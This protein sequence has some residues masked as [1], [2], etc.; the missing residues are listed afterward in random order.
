MQMGWSQFVAFVTKTEAD[1]CPGR[2]RSEGRDAAA[3]MRP[4]ARSRRPSSKPSLQGDTVGKADHRRARHARTLYRSGQRDLAGQAA[5][6]LHPAASGDR[7]SS[8]VA[9]SIARPTSCAPSSNCVIACVPATSGSR[10]AASIRTSRATLIPEPTFALLKAEGPLPVA[11]DT[12]VESYLAGRR[13][14]L[15]RE[16]EEVGALAD[17]GK[18]DGVDLTGGE[19]VISPVQANTPPEAEKLK[20]A[21][22]ALLPTTKITDVLLDVDSW[23]RFHRLLHASTQRPAAR[24]QAGA[25]VGDPGGRHQSRPQSH[26][27]RDPWRHLSAACAGS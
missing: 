17:Q 27:R 12:N 5:A 7:S 20:E 3:V 4:F 18:L 22:Y 13:A 19:L 8:R 16:I 9:R 10:A 26:G 21:V 23:T 25:A 14:A 6:A 2:D 24:Q 11:I 1:R 15:D